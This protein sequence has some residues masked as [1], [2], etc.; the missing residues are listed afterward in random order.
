MIG[1]RAGRAIGHRD[2]HIDDLAPGETVAGPVTKPVF[3]CESGRRGI[4]E[5]TIRQK[6][7]RSQLRRIHKFR[8]EVV[9]I[10]VIIQCQHA[11]RGVHRQFRTV[12]SAILI[13]Q[14]DRRLVGDLEVYGLQRAYVG[15]VE[16][17]VCKRVLS[18]I[19]GL[20]RILKRSIGLQRER[21]VSRRRI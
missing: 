21:A 2:S 5:R 14:G 7:E 9:A 10:S 16:D 8:D 13:R 11:L 19:A 6:N 15:S 17:P 4:V 18:Q 12:T 20:R 3:P 1:D